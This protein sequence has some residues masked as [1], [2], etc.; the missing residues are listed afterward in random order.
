MKTTTNLSPE[1]IALATKKLAQYKKAITQYQQLFEQDI[2]QA[3]QE[4]ALM[5]QLLEQIATLEAKLGISSPSTVAPSDTQDACSLLDEIYPASNVIKYGDSNYQATFQQLIKQIFANPKGNGAAIY[6]KIEN[7]KIYF[8]KAASKDCFSTGHLANIR[9]CRL[10]QAP[11]DFICLISSPS[12]EVTTLYNLDTSIVAKIV[13]KK[14]LYEDP[15]NEEREAIEEYVWNIQEPVDFLVTGLHIKDQNGVELFK[16]TY[17]P[18]LEKGLCTNLNKQAQTVVF[19]DTRPA[20]TYNKRNRTNHAIERPTTIYLIGLVNEKEQTLKH[21]VVLKNM[22]KRVK[23][24]FTQAHS[25]IEKNIKVDFDFDKFI[26]NGKVITYDPDLVQGQPQLYI[27]AGLPKGTYAIQFADD[28]GKRSATYQLDKA[29]NNGVIKL[30]LDMS[31]LDD[32]DWSKT[33]I[34]SAIENGQNSVYQHL[35]T[36]ILEEMNK[37][38][39]SMNKSAEENI[40]KEISR[41]SSAGKNMVDVVKAL[42]TEEIPFVK[43]ICGAIDLIAG[44]ILAVRELIKK[45]ETYNKRNICIEKTDNMIDTLK[46][47][48]ISN[49]NKDIIQETW[50]YYVELTKGNVTT[51]IVISDIKTTFGKFLT[52]K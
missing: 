16:K 47:H 30:L 41:L 2:L 13:A 33:A 3:T 27:G 52:A 36:N 38:L 4:Q 14:R 42:T 24:H 37:L 19:Q 10:H 39:K 18:I 11:H 17:T 8:I 7:K 1:K 22:Q 9:P 25:E 26:L 48:T 44:N 50:D 5:E 43:G 31:A 35:L 20:Y 21:E 46:A 28:N 40:L 32:E 23:I 51:G 45:R 29:T 34:V 6:E 49:A 15:I 12:F